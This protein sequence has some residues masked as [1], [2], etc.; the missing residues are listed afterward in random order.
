MV[1]GA[2]TREGNGDLAW[3]ADAAVAEH[4]V[5]YCLVEHTVKGEFSIT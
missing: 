5:G 3:I 4:S 2:A 1:K